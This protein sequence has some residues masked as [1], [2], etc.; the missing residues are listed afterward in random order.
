[1]NDDR[2]RNH[3]TE[4]YEK[5]YE[6]VSLSWVSEN[7]QLLHEILN[8]IRSGDLE[9]I[10]SLIRIIPPDFEARFGKTP[11]RHVKN[12]V[13]SLIQI[14]AI[15]AMDAGV[16]A[17]LCIRHAEKMSVRTEE[18]ESI[19]QLMRI[20]DQAKVE[21]CRLSHDMNAAEINDYRIRKAVQYIHEHL[22]EKIT[23]RKLAETAGISC[24]YFSRKF[25]EETGKTISEYIQYSRIQQ[26]KRML[27]NTDE[28]LS[29]ISS[30]LSFSSQNHFQKV[31]R[32]IEKKTPLQYRR[33]NRK[34]MI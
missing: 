3:E 21:F 16:S 1:M 17:S 9:Q 11:L 10:Q 24:E 19:E 14:M 22:S 13:I 2:M 4:L 25:H 29:S 12:L 32:Q 28:S 20:A 8:S 33:E 6:D 26:A 27:V 5:V 34:N 18:A 7:L 30:Y 23:R 31:F 15:T